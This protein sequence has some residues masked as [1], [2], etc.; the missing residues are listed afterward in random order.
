MKDLEFV[1]KFYKTMHT[2]WAVLCGI[3]TFL[4]VVALFNSHGGEETFTIFMFIVMTAIMY[5]AGRV[6]ISFNEII[7]SRFVAATENILEITL[8][9]ENKFNKKEETNK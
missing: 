4:L 2:I 5:F 6:C 8:M 7:F 1:E 3:I 9:L